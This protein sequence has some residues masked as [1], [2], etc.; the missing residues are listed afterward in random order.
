MW[1]VPPVIS[2]PGR[3]ASI[4]II[5]SPALVNTVYG[6]WWHP[7]DGRFLRGDCSQPNWFRPS[8]QEE[9]AGGL[10]WSYSL[11]RTLGAGRYVALGTGGAEPI[12]AARN[13]NS[14]RLVDRPS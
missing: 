9:M 13:S 6:R 3:R 12:H 5:T 4:G 10:E 2:T 7:K 8:R 11:P 14:F 1:L